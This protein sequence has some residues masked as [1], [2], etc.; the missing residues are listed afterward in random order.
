MT[1]GGVHLEEEKTY[2]EFIQ[3]ILDTRG[4]FNCGDGYH[5]RH[6]I[7]PKCLG[8]GNEEENLIDLYAKEHFIAHKL[9]AL[10][11]PDNNGLQYAWWAMSNMK[12]EFTKERYQASPE[13]YEEAKTAFSIM[14]REKSCM[15]VVQLDLLGNYISKYKSCAEAEFI[16]GI[17]SRYIVDC[18]NHKR[19][20]ACGFIFISEDEYDSNK[21]YRYKFPGREVVQFTIDGSYIATFINPPTAAREI[22]VNVVSI[23]SCCCEQGNTAGGFRW[24]YL[25]EWDGKKL[26]PIEYDYKNQRAIVDIK[27]ETIQVNRYDNR[28]RYICTYD[29]VNDAAFDAGCA[30]TNISRCC[31]EIHK[32][33]DNCYWR[34][35]NECDGANDIIIET[36]KYNQHKPV[37]QLSLDGEFIA[38]Y[39]SM[40]EAERIAGVPAGCISG[41]CCGTQFTAG[42]Y[43]W[44]LASEYDKGNIPVYHPRQ[45][46]AVI[47]LDKNGTFVRKYNSIKEAQDAA[48]VN[49]CNIIICCQKSNLSAGGFQWIYEKDYDPNKIYPPVKVHERRVVK[50]TI[51]MKYIETFDSV[52]LA[53]ASVGKKSPAIIRNCKHPHL[54]A[55]G[56]KWMYE[57]DYIKLLTDT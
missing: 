16:L 51:D 5:E 26:S 6:H 53:A 7:L 57:E 46:V 8:G 24:M 18:K 1:S 30:S 32:M 3:N 10:E 4:R 47:Q 12:T 49:S 41:C 40:V 15:P 43:L 29:S 28:G 14:M 38:V 22:G 52:S 37:I 54:T 25:D 50:L 33:I 39:N 44:V 27:R 31:R 2:K 35:T 56:F 9:L 20:H 34:Y 21:N 13:E 48:G 11:N 42:N 23:R 36:Y 19:G 17:D 45:T 55:Y